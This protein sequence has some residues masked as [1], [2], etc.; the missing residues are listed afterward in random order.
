MSGDH[1]SPSGRPHRHFKVHD[2]V[3]HFGPLHAGI[4]QKAPANDFNAVDQASFQPGAVDNQPL[5]FV[6]PMSWSKMSSSI[7]G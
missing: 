2:A 6:Q 7:S 5:R 1:V 3:H 4:V